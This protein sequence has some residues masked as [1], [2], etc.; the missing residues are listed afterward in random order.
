MYNKKCKNTFL[1]L[2]A[3]LCLITLIVPFMQVGFFGNASVILKIVYYFTL[4]VFAICL[5]AIILIGIISLFKNNYMLLP[6][7]EFL[8]YVALFMLLLNLIIFAPINNVILSVGYSILAI[9]AFVMACL[10]DI[11]KLIKK[12]PRNFKNLVKTIK[13]EKEEKLQKQLQITSE[14]NLTEKP[15]EK[16]VE[17]TFTQTSMLEGDEVKIIP[18]DEDLI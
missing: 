16:V 17:V 6:F 14:E 5:V 8:A 7:Q 15:E 1:F 12:L 10:D 2:M 9:E 4:V 11:L 3:L 13:L 18:P